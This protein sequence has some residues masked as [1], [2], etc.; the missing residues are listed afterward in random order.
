MTWYQPGGSS[1]REPQPSYREPEPT[2]APAPPVEAEEPH[3]FRTAPPPAEPTAARSGGFVGRR[4]V[5][6][7]P[8]A[9]AV[10]LAVLI[11]VLFLLVG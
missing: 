7:G 3:Q 2:K 5:R 9:V 10:A 8:L 1:E 11:I 6:F 4:R